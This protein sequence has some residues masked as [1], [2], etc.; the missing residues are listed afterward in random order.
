LE[1]FRDDRD[2][3]SGHRDRPSDEADQLIGIS[4]ESV[5]GINPES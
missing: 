2:H 1:S 4:P 5:I 3:R